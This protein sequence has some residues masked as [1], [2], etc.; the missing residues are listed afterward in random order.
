M[1]KEN[2]EFDEMRN[3]PY[4]RQR[5]IL[6][7]IKKSECVKIEDLA[8]EFNV[9]TMTIYR[10]VQELVKAG[11]ARKVYG[12]VKAAEKEADKEKLPELIRPYTDTTIEERFKLRK[13]EKSAIARA[14]A[15]LVKD[16]EIIAIDPSTTTLHMCSYL[17]EKNIIVVTTS[18]SVALQFASSET[19]SVI[20]C[21][22]MLRKSALSVVG[23]LLPETLNRLNISKCFLSSRAFNY[24]RGL[25][26]A[27]M[28]ETEAKRNMIARSDKV[29]LLLDHSKFDKVAPFEVCSHKAVHSIITD[30]KTGEDSDTRKILDSCAADGVKVVLV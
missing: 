26:D 23:N 11:E 30:K 25:T 6:N 18:M 2:K 1:N 14:A 19:V 20:L 4:T 29:Y 16:G 13:E 15:E 28:E 7:K 12:G 17:Q 24:E 27:T 9:S 22:G 10:D 8:E 21:G 5:Q 3:L